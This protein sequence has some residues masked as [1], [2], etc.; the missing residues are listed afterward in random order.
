MST[1]ATFLK[2]FDN[3]SALFPVQGQARAE[4]HNGLEFPTI[5]DEQWKYTRVTPILD[6]EYQRHQWTLD[7]IDKFRIAGH[8]ARYMVFVNGAFNA[9]ISDAMPDG[10]RV[11]SMA[12]A[13]G[14]ERDAMLEHLGRY[15]A[16]KQNAFDALNTGYFTDGAFIHV[17]A[18]TEVSE[19]ICILNVNW[20]EAQATNARNL[21][22]IGANA[23]VHIVHQFEGIDCRHGFNNAVAEIL[24]EEGAQGHYYIVENEGPDTSLINATQVVQKKDSRFTVITVTKSGSLV[25]NN[26]NFSVTDRG[27]ESNLLGI[28]F[29]SGNQHVDNHTYADHQQPMCV[30]NELYKGV[31][32]DRSTGVFNGKIMV[33]RNA[34]QTNA[35]QSNQ[36]ILLSDR[37]TINTKPEL[38]IYADDVKCS[39]G[40]TVGQLDEEA[41]FYL[42]SR[43]LGKETASRLL[44][45]AFAADVLDKIEVAALRENIEL[46]IEQKFQ[47]AE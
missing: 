43:G 41:L 14:P 39:H 10:V 21:L 18:N 47:Q 46:F 23:R 35:F 42:Q 4:I 29:T 24:V 19:P 7:S 31:M 13:T 30:S 12:G 37:A 40:C 9:E 33:H 5:R 6:A 16:Y 38:E 1:K 28:Y 26:L 11:T 3:I 34:Q 36:N 22:V 2:Q 8:Q 27:C 17:E 32:T 15:T 44:I 20:G 45:R 25:R